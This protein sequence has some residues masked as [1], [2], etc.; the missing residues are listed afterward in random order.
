MENV[1]IALSL[2]PKEERETIRHEL[3]GASRRRNSLGAH[4]PQYSGSRLPR[5]SSV[6][7]PDVTGKLISGI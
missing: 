1:A 6:G 5:I 4:S 3:T 7:I 2:V